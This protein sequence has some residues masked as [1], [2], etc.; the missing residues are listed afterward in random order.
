[1]LVKMI[2]LLQNQFENIQRRSNMADKE[3]ELALYVQVDNP[4]FT[5]TTGSEVWKQ[6][7]SKLESKTGIRVR[8]Y[9][10]VE[11]PNKCIQTIKIKGSKV[12]GLESSDEY[13]CAIP[14]GFAEGFIKGASS[15]QYKRRDTYTSNKVVLKLSRGDEVENHD[16][17]QL[18]IEADRFIT[19]DGY[20]PWLKIDVELDGLLAWVKSTYGKDKVNGYHIELD[21]I[22]PCKVLKVIPSTTTDPEEKKILDDLWDNHFKKK[23]I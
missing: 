9:E 11:G 3:T 20:L 12:G 7:E 13:S 18:T 21:K 14:E 16:A 6:Y 5:P 17:P 8:V 10:G 1:M 15:V 22:L 4:N 23:L 19:E 2:L